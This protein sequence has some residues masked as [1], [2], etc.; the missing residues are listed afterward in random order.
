MAVRTTSDLVAAIIAVDTKNITDVSP[1][2]SAASALVDEACS[3]DD[4]TDAQL[5]VIETWL[6]AH[7]YTIRDPRAESEKAGSI[8]VKYQSKVAL[9][10]STSHYGQMAMLLDHKGGL[11]ALSKRIEKGKKQSVSITWWGSEDD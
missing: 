6:A 9:N 3:T 8:S 7:V 4:Y 2:I 1:F 10:L 5:T 11:A